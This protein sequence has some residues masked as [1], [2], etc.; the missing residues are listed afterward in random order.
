VAVHHIKSIR[1]ALTQ[2]FLLTLSDGSKVD[3]TRTYYY[4]FK[5]FLG[6]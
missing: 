3:V 1:P 6:L 2:K 5:E 4:I